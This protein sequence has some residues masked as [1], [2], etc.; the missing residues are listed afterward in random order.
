MNNEK[1]EKDIKEQLRKINMDFSIKKAPKYRLKE[2][3]NFYT[4]D[5]I[6]DLA[7]E[8]REYISKSKKKAE[9]VDLLEEILLKNLEN[10]SSY[11]TLSERETI[12]KVIKKEDINEINMEKTKNFKELGYIY[13]FYHNNDIQIVC[14][15]EI[16]DRYMIAYE[17]DNKERIKMNN[18]LSDY[19]RALQRIY[20]VFEANQLVTVWNKYNKEKLNEEFIFE[21]MDIIGR[22]QNYLWW[23][24]PYIIS[25]YFMDIEEYEDFLQ[26][27]MEK[28]YYMPTKK[29]IEYYMEEEFDIDNLY[30]KKML[31]YFEKQKS[32]N[33]VQLDDLMLS[34]EMGCIF[35]NSF[36]DIINIINDSGF[37]FKNL[38]EL[39]KFMRNY[40]DLS[41]NTRKWETKGYKPVELSEAKSN[42]LNDNNVIPFEKPT[43]KKKIGRNEPCSCG[44][45][46]KY[47]F[48]CGK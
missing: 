37:K 5:K 16:A 21:F 30:Y 39:N 3:L 20:G 4:K 10:D 46:K 43:K 12:A 44:S 42:V 48:C 9:M 23:H 27:R 31:D 17:K 35:N 22:R 41:N 11:I 15:N 19:T 32:L 33:E 28:E 34:I 25:D 2:C 40:I 7:N 13:W 26:S 36:Q 38:D 47:K 1:L 8:H 18:D 6:F 45:G 29:E 24:S 14:P